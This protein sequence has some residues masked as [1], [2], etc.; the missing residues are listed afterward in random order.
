MN[1]YVSPFFRLLQ[2]ILSGFCSFQHTDYVL[3]LL[4][5]YFS[6]FLFLLFGN[7]VYD[8]LKNNFEFWFFIAVIEKYDF[9]LDIDFLFYDL[10]KLS[11]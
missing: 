6:I 9:F 2:L 3:I 10:D 4:D 7:A 8:T 11:Y 1:R 5:L